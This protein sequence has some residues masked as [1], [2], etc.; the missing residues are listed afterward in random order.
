MSWD[1]EEAATRALREYVR[2]VTEALG[3]SGECSL[4][5][6]ERPASAYVAV[7]GHLPGFPDRDLA[8]VWDERDGWAAAVETHGGED[9]VVRARLGGDVLP[10][11]D[12]V[13]AWLDQ[14]QHG[15]AVSLPAPRRVGDLSVRL[16]TYN[17]AELS[18][19]A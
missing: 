6:A 9:L 1:F 17:S 15:A 5:Q 2:R 8:L 18:R 10:P 16:R 3:L 12:V 19:T 14:V 7:D 4:V 11:P 13:A